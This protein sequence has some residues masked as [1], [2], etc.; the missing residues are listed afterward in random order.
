MLPP[1]LELRRDVEKTLESA[2]KLQSETRVRELLEGLN[3]KIA[4]T[5][6][7][8]TSGPAT[9]IAKLDIEALI[10]RWRRSEL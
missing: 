10:E 7:S 3:D 1:A 2:R 6:A 8:T 4:S 5:N 9:H